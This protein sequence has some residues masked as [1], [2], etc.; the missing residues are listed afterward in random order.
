MTPVVVVCYMAACKW[1]GTDEDG[2]GH[3]N[4]TAITIER[5]GHCDGYEPKE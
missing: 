4:R 5:D 1:H 2:V 3:C